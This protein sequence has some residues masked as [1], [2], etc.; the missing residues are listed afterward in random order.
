MPSVLGTLSVRSKLAEGADTVFRTAAAMV[1][2][3][4]LRQL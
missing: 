4:P 2:L 3:F 1:I